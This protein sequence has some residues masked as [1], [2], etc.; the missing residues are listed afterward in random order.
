MLLSVVS[1]ISSSGDTSDRDNFQSQNYL[2]TIRH[3]CIYMLSWTDMPTVSFRSRAG[4]VLISLCMSAEISRL[5]KG[6]SLCPWECRLSERKL[7]L[8][9]LRKY[10]HIETRASWWCLLQCTCSSNQSVPLQNRVP[11]DLRLNIFI[12]DFH[13]C[14]W[15]C[16][17]NSCSPAFK[18][19]LR[20]G[21]VKGWKIEGLDVCDK[22]EIWRFKMI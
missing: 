14:E 5:R 13:F 19:L 8:R 2:W 18:F 7:F 11:R 12:Y 16:P 10:C 15:R 1:L 3:R 21:C 6:H 4:T 17:Y 20:N 22:V 9:R